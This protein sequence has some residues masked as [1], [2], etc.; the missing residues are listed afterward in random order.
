MTNQANVDAIA[1]LLRRAMEKEVVGFATRDRYSG[2]VLEPRD[3]IHV[4]IALHM[5]RAGC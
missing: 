2:E 4:R 5:A 1:R 3:D